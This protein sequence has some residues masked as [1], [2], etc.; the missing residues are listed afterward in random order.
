M[1]R[2]L[3]SIS[4]SLCLTVALGQKNALDSLKKVLRNSKTK[5]DSLTLYNQL[6]LAW[7]NRQLDSAFAISN[8][9]IQRATSSEDTL[10]LALAYFY[11]AKLLAGVRRHDKIYAAYQECEKAK[12]LLKSRK[13]ETLLLWINTYSDGLV[14][15]TDNFSNN[16]VLTNKSFLRMDS[17]Y[18]SALSHCV[19]NYVAQENW[20]IAGLI[21]EDI[22]EQD[23]RR[24]WWVNAPQDLHITLLADRMNLIDQTINY[25]LKGH[26]SDRVPKIMR[27]RAYY[28]YYAENDKDKAEQYF[29]SGYQLANAAGNLFESAMNLNGLAYCD[30]AQKEYDSTLLKAHE[31]LATAYR[32]NDVD[33]IMRYQQTFYDAY[34]GMKQPDKALPY[35]E[36]YLALKDSLIGRS[37][38]LSITEM[39][40][41]N[42]IF[43]T[44]KQVHELQLKDIQN[45]NQKFIL[46]LFAGAMA[47]I[48]L[49]IVVIFRNRQLYLK[50]IKD[51]EL[52]QKLREQ[53]E[54]IG[55]DLHDSLGGQLSSIS[56]GLNHLVEDKRGTVQTIQGM[57]DKALGELRNSL[58]VMD[59]ESISIFEIEQRINGLFWQHRKLETPVDLI[60]KIEDALFP[61]QLP[62]SMGGDLYR[63]IEEAT[64]NCI[65]HSSAKHLTIL[66]EKSTSNIQIVISD[67]G[68]GF[69]PEEKFDSEHYGLKN[70]KVRAAKMNFT[71][72]I[73]SSPGEGTNI[74]ISI[75]IIL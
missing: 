64:N 30:L 6:T 16:N 45:Q 41:R 33:Q 52:L 55:R 49:L 5:F 2:L 57:A 71:L 21:Q 47:M 10:Q 27:H 13:F 39:E 73:S 58:W 8:Q 70:M 11:R 42:K 60:L 1:I 53:K 65:K 66:F 34:L 69:N 15:R 26:L 37:S 38:V 63:I 19:A 32:L 43:D 29:R 59:K 28:F 3:L 20:L 35:I 17:I 46:Q 50:K 12:T 62:S 56:L 18:V 44:E 24:A 74:F 75:P 61:V 22:L 67:D 36:R 51:I 40:T 72:S 54:R 4:L 14:L 25:F 48:L 68:I 7:S 23:I 9:T 31:A